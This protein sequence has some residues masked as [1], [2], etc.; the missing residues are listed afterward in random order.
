MTNEQS[1][2]HKLE[3]V[4]L[5]DATL[6]AQQLAPAAAHGDFVATPVTVDGKEAAVVV[7]HVPGRSRELPLENPMEGL[8]TD[9]IEKRYQTRRRMLGQSA[10]EGIVRV[11]EPLTRSQIHG[12]L[13]R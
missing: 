4:I 8:D 3:T 1:Q 6:G 9:K 13:P 12:R 5:A 11:E 7:T 2:G 10:S